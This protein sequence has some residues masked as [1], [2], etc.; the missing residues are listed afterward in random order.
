M[1]HAL[2]GALVAA[3]LTFSCTLKSERK[4]FEVPPRENFDSVSLALGAHCGSLDCHGRVEQNMRLYAKFG[5]R[6][7]DN[8]TPD[9]RDTSLDEHDANYQS[10]VA[11]E[12]EIL[13]AVWHAGGARAERLTLVRKARGTEAHK[14]KTV[15]AIGSAGDLCLLSWLSGVVDE[16][17]C[18][19]VESP[20]T[21]PFAE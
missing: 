8:D 5:L 10:V 7:D 2:P 17:A 16:P 12:P 15:F 14:G 20:P 19:E 13:A 9:G 18:Q 1:N 6:L 4:S 3:A 21:S 11:L